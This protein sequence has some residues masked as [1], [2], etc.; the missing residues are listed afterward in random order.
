MNNN[1]VSAITAAATICT[2][3]SYL[4][5]IVARQTIGRKHFKPAKWNLG[6]W[7][8]PV[9]VIASFYIA[10]LFVVL[11]LPQ[12]YPVNAVR[13]LPSIYSSK[14]FRII[15]TKIDL[16]LIRTFGIA[17]TQLRTHS[18]WWNHCH[19]AWRLVLSFLTRREILVRRTEAYH[20]RG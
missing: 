9:S 4:I 19:R 3:L 7:S 12:L 16:L 1:P 15:E 10:F 14:S 20:H 2:N 11:M 17:N 5:P 8:I 18:N 6:A 13:S